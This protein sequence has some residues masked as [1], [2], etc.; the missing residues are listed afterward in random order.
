MAGK[1]SKTTTPG[2]GRKAGY[3]ADPTHPPPGLSA[4]GAGDTADAGPVS[5]EAPGESV[6]GG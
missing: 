2:T 1:F 3:G 4:E 6:Q 5:N